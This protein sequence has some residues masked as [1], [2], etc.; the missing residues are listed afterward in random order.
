MIRR[1]ITVMLCAI[2]LAIGFAGVLE[3]ADASDIHGFSTTWCNS[4]ELISLASMEAGGVVNEDNVVTSRGTEGVVTSQGPSI[5]MNEVGSRVQVTFDQPLF[6]TQFLFDNVDA[7]DAV[8]VDASLGDLRQPIDASS[9][10]GSLVRA[11][12]QSAFGLTAEARSQRD[13]TGQ[14]DVFVG[15]T[16]ILLTNEGSTPIDVVGAIGCPAFQLSSETISAPAWDVDRQEFVGEYEVTLAN[17][18]ANPRTTALRLQESAASTTTIDDVTISASLDSPGFSTA[19]VGLLRMSTEL[20]RR[21]NIEFDGLQNLSLLDTP[22]ELRDG[23]DHTIRLEV[24]F[25]PDFN[26]PAWAEGV[27]APAPSF[28]VRG[29]V[30]DITVGVGGRLTQEGVDLEDIDTLEA[31]SPSLVV[32]H[33]LLGEPLSDANG[34]ITTSERIDVINTGEAAISEVLVDYSLLELWGEGTQVLSVAGQATGGCGGLFSTAFTG[35]GAT[36]VLFDAD[37]L[38]AGG[39]CSIELQ[40]EVLPG[41]CLLYTSPSPRDATLSRMPS[42]A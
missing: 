33:E 21:R 28:Q 9:V 40:A 22:L 19:S 17:R 32:E 2:L 6:F 10:R 25:T 8:R 12:E 31:P 5:R 39:R 1:N 24:G 38:D 7:A 11:D 37:G 18:L 29:A 16:E 34:V 41:T 13:G 20:E 35:V 3:D 26:D 27:A 14:I 4:P 23:T 30:D 15:T 42:S 36:V